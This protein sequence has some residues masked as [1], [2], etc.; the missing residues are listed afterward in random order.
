MFSN[1]IRLSDTDAVQEFVEAAGKCDFDI[2]ASYGRALVD[3]KS[4]LGMLYLGVSKELTIH[5]SGNDD[6]FES[7]VK[8][9]A[10]G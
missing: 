1:T 6:V 7:V 4:L 2:N 8:K 10:V 3:A 5:C 9:Y